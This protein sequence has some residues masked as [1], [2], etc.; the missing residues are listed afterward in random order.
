MVGV[1]GATVVTV[2]HHASNTKH[3]VPIRKSDFFIYVG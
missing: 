2:P 3:V 1:V